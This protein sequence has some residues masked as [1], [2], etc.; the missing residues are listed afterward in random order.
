MV[1]VIEATLHQPQ[2]QCNGGF[3]FSFW[4][5]DLRGFFTVEYL[6]QFI[7]VFSKRDWTAEEIRLYLRP[8]ALVLS[9]SKSP[10]HQVAC[11]VFDLIQQLS[12]MSNLPH[13]LSAIVMEYEEKRPQFF[14]QPND[15]L[16]SRLP[17]SVMGNSTIVRVYDILTGLRPQAPEFQRL[18]RN[19]NTW[20]KPQLHHSLPP[21]L[22]HPNPFVVNH[23]KKN[24]LPP[25]TILSSW[26]DD[27][28]F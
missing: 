13:E 15:D 9:M 25:R 10:Q 8:V 28:L 3:A 21:P 26:S 24:G 6:M 4:S 14:L 16:Q 18:W 23:N 2:Y 12:V 20:V 1:I 27:R 7:A 5:Y 19:L 17:D 11:R 22:V